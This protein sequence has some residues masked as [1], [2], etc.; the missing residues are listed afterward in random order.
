MNDRIIVITITLVLTV[1]TGSALAV[2]CSGLH[3]WPG[4]ISLGS[5]LGLYEIGAVRV[6]ILRDIS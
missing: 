6:N 5:S 4:M 2:D 3:V 1:W